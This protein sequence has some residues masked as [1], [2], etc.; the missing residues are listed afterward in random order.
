[1]I[2][3]IVSR[4]PVKEEE[5]FKSNSILKKVTLIKQMVMGLMDC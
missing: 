5:N 1:M 2:Y 4:A 3:G